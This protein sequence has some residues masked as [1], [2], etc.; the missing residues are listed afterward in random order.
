MK[1]VFKRFIV[2]IGKARAACAQSFTPW[3]QATIE[4][5]RRDRSPRTLVI[6]FNRSHVSIRRASTPRSLYYCLFAP[7][8]YIIV[9]QSTQRQRRGCNIIQFV[10]L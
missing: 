2:A 3:Q 4:F 6:K 10:Y 7:H 9:L 5:T 8:V 1:S